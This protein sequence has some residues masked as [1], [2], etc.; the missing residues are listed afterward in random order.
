MSAPSQHPH[1]T[2][3][4]LSTGARDQASPLC[5]LEFRGR[6]DEPGVALCQ[7]LSDEHDQIVCNG[8]DKLFESEYLDDF[9]SLRCQ[10]PGYAS[11]SRPLLFLEAIPIKRYEVGKLVAVEMRGY[12][13]EL[14]ELLGDRQSA[15]SDNPSLNGID[16]DKL[17]LSEFYTMDGKEWETTLFMELLEKVEEP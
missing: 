11:D 7:F 3:V 5:G 4:P 2:F 8:L 14:R 9:M 16:W 15:A 1:R 12:M 10:L 17:Y 13:N 6:D